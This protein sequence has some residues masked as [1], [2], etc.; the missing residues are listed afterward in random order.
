MV[1][2]KSFDIIRSIISLPIYY[3]M[4]ILIKLR[5]KVA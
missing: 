5:G 4:F 1:P 3:H 2:K